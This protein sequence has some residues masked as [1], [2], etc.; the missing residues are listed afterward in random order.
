MKLYLR[1]HTTLG[2]IATDAG[3]RVLDKTGNVISGLW[4]AGETVGSVHGAERI[5]GNGLAAACTFGRL[6][7]TAGAEK[8]LL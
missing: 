8:Q 3:A 5:G 1:I 6:A 4:A 7:G 2:G